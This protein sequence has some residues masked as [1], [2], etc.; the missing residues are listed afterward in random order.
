[1]L[2]VEAVAFATSIHSEAGWAETFAPKAATTSG[3]RVSPSDVR[4]T[5]AK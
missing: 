3:P 1:M 2:I 5:P 4:W